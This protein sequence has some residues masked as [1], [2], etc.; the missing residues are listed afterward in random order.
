VIRHNADVPGLVQL[1]AQLSVEAVDPDHPAHDFFVAR[2]E[3][4]RREFGGFI[5]DEQHAGRIDPEL[6]ADLTATLFVAA[7]DGLQTQWMLDPSIDM[8]EHVAYLWHLVTR[9]A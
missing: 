7:S 5:R 6:D 2:Y 3:T 1:Y 8:A 9:K 4:V